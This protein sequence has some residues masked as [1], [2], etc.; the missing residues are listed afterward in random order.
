[1]YGTT[2][3]RRRRRAL[4]E[5]HGGDADGTHAMMDHDGMKMSSHHDDADAH[6]AMK[7]AWTSSGGHGDWSV[8][9]H[10][11]K[12]KRHRQHAHE[13]WADWIETKMKR[14][15]ELRDAARDHARASMQT[16]SEHVANAHA[17]KK[18]RVAN[19]AEMLHGGKK[20]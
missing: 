11:E 17:K 10:H 19:V 3:S 16:A 13:S 18:E 9:S 12:M 5:H 6:H 1:L 2:L 7:K 20:N 15:A 4:L 8:G 14:G